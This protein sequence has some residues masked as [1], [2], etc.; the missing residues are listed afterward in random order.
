M[1][2]N[3][4]G[5]VS[6][7]QKGEETIYQVDTNQQLPINLPDEIGHKIFLC[8]KGWNQKDVLTQR[9]PE[10][11]NLNCHGIQKWIS[12]D[13]RNM[14]SFVSRMEITQ[15]L[16]TIK[17]QEIETESK[18]PFHLVIK[19]AGKIIH[20]LLVLGKTEETNDIIIF[21]KAG[22]SDQSQY[23]IRIATLETAL[24][25]YLNRNNLT[26]YITPFGEMFTDS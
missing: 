3:S 6:R 9:Y 4:Y 7:I 14:P 1:C 11:K 8:L 21:E 17:P 16:K 19:S 13:S 25:T 26:F 24:S 18:F 22:S 12:K 15:I 5:S 23:P 20:S 2:E 10:L